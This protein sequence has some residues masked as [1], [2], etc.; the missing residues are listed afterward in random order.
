MLSSQLTVGNGVG[1]VWGSVGG[2][3]GVGGTDRRGFLE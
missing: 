3:V 1:V 2:R